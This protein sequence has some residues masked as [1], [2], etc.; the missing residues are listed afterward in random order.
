MRLVL[1]SK[2]VLLPSFPFP[3]LAEYPPMGKLPAAQGPLDLFTNFELFQLFTPD[4]SAMGPFLSA[5]C[6]VLRG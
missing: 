5:G 6:E 2:D 3:L 4:V 1:L